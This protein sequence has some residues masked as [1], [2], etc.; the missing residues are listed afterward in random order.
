[1]IKET[2]IA[3][4]KPIRDIVYETLRNAI[5]LG[6][7][8]P[9]QRLVEKEYADKYQI[10]RTPIREAIRKLESEGFVEYIPRKGVIVKTF[11][12]ADIIE[13]YAIRMSLESL[14]LRFI[15]ENITAA[16]IVLLRGL[17]KK[18]EEAEQTGDTTKLIIICRE[19]NTALL[20]AG[21][22]PRL[23]GM[24]ATLQDY[25]ERF[26]E[27]TFSQG[28]RRRSAVKEH[29]TILEAVLERDENKAVKLTVEH[30]EAS[31]GALLRSLGIHYR[32]DDR[33]GL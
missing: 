28:L 7:L 3:A 18:M 14:A 12:A 1:M 9:G 27:I 5:L 13:I 19:F 31:K 4:L 24:I 17:V 8:K 2:E 20:A 10:S 11:E 22:M 21:R 30:L 6:Q 29:K 15:I 32:E 23:T 26:R 33:H 16:D 25:L